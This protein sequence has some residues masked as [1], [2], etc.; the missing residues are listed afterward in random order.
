MSDDDR[1]NRLRSFWTA[2]AGGLGL[3][4]LVLF[5]ALTLYPEINPERLLLPLGVIATALG[6]NFV[7]EFLV[8]RTTRPEQEYA[9]RQ[10]KIALRWGVPLLVPGLASLGI[11]VSQYPDLFDFGLSMAVLGVLMM[12]VGVNIAAKLSSPQRTSVEHHD[13]GLAT[14]PSQEPS[15]LV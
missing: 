9:G 14:A 8:L 15:K 3:G 12:S 11:G 7:I 4:G 5:F 1:V 6:V 13:A 2:L 10:A